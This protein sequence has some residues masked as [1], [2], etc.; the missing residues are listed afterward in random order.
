[1]LV[2]NDAPQNT[3]AAKPRRTVTELESQSKTVFHYLV[4]VEGEHVQRC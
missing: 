1:M 3:E 4:K 2:L